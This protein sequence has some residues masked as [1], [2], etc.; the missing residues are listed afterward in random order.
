MAR[1]KLFTAINL[2]GLAISMSVG[3]LIIT[4]VSDL[5]SYDNFHENKDNIYRVLTSNQQ[6]NEPRITFA[7]S[8]VETGRNIRESFTGVEGVTTLS[9]GFNGIA[10][11]E[12]NKLPI[13]AYWADNSFLKI[14]LRMKN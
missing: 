13:Q 9:L 3:L 2:V 10:E 12:D 14:F 6:P 4:F 5:T 7:S 1:S 11:I 8:S